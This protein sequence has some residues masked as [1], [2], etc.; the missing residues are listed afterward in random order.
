MSNDGVDLLSNFSTSQVAGSP[1]CGCSKYKEIPIVPC[2]L[3]IIKISEP[4]TDMVEH[5]VPRN[6]EFLAGGPR[7]RQ[8]NPIRL[9]SGMDFF[10]ITAPSSYRPP[11][12]LNLTV[13][14]EAICSDSKHP[15]LTVEGTPK[16]QSLSKAV[17]TSKI[18]QA[19]RSPLKGDDDI[20]SGNLFNMLFRFF[21]EILTTRV[22]SISAD[23]CGLPPGFPYKSR[24]NLTANIQVYPADLCKIEIELPALCEP[25]SIKYEKKVSHGR[26]F[27][28][29]IKM[30][31]TSKLILI[32]RII[33][34]F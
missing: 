12:I 31:L 23:T 10:Q 30:M 18:I 21:K 26:L 33:R 4:N 3:K 29:L 19:Y 5:P 7:N 24:S 1:V 34:N 8:G 17:E 25:E 6:V 16:P 15:E 28:I 13:E 9:V 32:I 22:I 11:K 27:Q 2:N 20:S 14:T